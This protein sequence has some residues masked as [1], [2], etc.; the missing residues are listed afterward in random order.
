MARFASITAEG[1]DEL[2]K[3]KDAKNTQRATV[4]AWNAFLS[5]V[6]EKGIHFDGNVDKTYM[7]EVLRTFYFELRKQNGELYSLNAFRAQRHGLQ[8]KFKAVYDVDII[9]DPAFEKCNIAFLAQ[10]VS[11]KKEG[12]GK[13][14]HKPPITNDDLLKLYSSPALSTD[15]PKSL[16]RKVFFDI[17]YFLCRRGQENLRT[18]TKTSFVVKHDEHGVEFVT[19]DIEEFD[20]NHR[21]NDKDVDGG[22]IMAT[23]KRNCAVAAF[24][25]Y[26]SKLNPKI[27]ALF[28]RPKLSKFNIADSRPWYDAQVIGVNS[29]TN[30]MKDISVAA[31][32]SMVYTNHSIRATCITQLDNGGNE[33]RHIMA[34]SGHKSE[35]SIRSYSKT[36]M[37]VKRKMCNMLSSTLGGDDIKDRSFLDTIDLSTLDNDM[38]KPTTPCT[39]TTSSFQLNMALQQSN[40]LNILSS[41]KF[42]PQFSFP[43]LEKQSK[44]SPEQTVYNNCTFNINKVQDSPPAKRRRRLRIFSDSEDSE[45]DESAQELR[46]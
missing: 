46:N 29:L 3:E 21:L 32:L 19:K 15:H 41:H 27:D 31:E 33:A 20:K 12:K 44:R 6:K 43:S 39:P 45:D 5:Y 30:M 4:T 17:M 35:S 1:V 40:I 26:V 16:L 18:L 23:G 13:V 24:K 25:L 38:V 8:R 14:N 9:N 28:Q 22:V 11:L 7:N 42:I 37:S 10:S 2:I 34:V 36:G